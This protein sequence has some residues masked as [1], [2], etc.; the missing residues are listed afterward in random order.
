MTISGLIYRMDD[1]NI[2]WRKTVGVICMV[3]T[4][5]LC[6]SC[7]D[8]FNYTPESKL[9][10]KASQVCFSA[11]NQKGLITVAPTAGLAATT[12][13][14]WCHVHVSSDSTVV[15]E[16]D[17]NE[18]LTGRSTEVVLSS[19]DGIA[20]VP[21]TQYGAVWYV[22]GDSTYLVG[23][24]PTIVFIPLHSDYNYFVDTPDWASGVKVEDG[25]EVSLQ[26][27]ETG[28]VRRTQITFRSEKGERSISIYQFGLN[29]IAGTYQLRYGIPVS[30]T[31]NR[32]T[33]VTVEIEQSLSD[34][35]LFLVSGMSVIPNVKI[36][37]TYDPLTFTLSISAGQSLGCVGNQQRYVFTALASEVGA[38]I[39]TTVSYSAP[40][41]IDHKTVKPSFSFTDSEGYA[42]F[43]ETGTERL[44]Y[45]HGILTIGTIQDKA[46]LDIDNFLGYADRIMN[47][48]F[49]KKSN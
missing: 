28:E 19:V 11:S 32:D 43:D 13:A 27:N 29:D 6:A 35:T 45:I 4:L 1:M 34:S 26:A 38:H 39:S 16:V 25:Y 36:P 42:Y 47:P 48:V 2:L 37:F 30:Q 15:V 49:T 40:V 3:A 33:V 18:E 31:E 5:L 46:S 22:M 23:D 8:D 7:G 14:S 10:L 20:K 12:Q 41:V 21:V 9:K 17:R 24:E 44:A